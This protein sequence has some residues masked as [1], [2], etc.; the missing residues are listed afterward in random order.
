MDMILNLAWPDGWAEGSQTFSPR[1]SGKLGLN[2]QRR[3]RNHGGLN[4]SVSLFPWQDRVFLLLPPG[5]GRPQLPLLSQ[6]RPREVEGA[7]SPRSGG[8]SP[9]DAEAGQEG[10]RA[11][12]RS[13]QFR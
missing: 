3:V 1:R 9:S 12:V 8:R 4:D 13:L 11:R 2:W 5:P 7:W 6:R 10:V